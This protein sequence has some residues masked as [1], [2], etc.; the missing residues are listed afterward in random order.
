MQP[1]LQPTHEICLSLFPTNLSL[2][3]TASKARD[4]RDP[5]HKKENRGSRYKKEGSGKG[6]VFEETS[7]GDV[8]VASFY[9]SASKIGP[10]QGGTEGGEMEEKRGRVAGRTTGLAV[11]PGWHWRFV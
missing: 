1:L 3:Q 7:L 5:R 9:R 2:T 6:R 11:G 10:R 8:G 4:V